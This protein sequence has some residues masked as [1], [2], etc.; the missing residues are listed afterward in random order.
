MKVESNFIDS[1]ILSLPGS[2]F[3][4]YNKI[5]LKNKNK[6]EI[7]YQI[8]EDTCPWKTPEQ[9]R[10]GGKSHFVKEYKGEDCLI[11]LKF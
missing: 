5:K 7:I 9:A 4:C 1:E 10:K 11:F 2:F 8:S 6:N 3:N